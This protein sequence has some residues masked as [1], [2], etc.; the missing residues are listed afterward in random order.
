MSFRQGWK[1]A[2]ERSKQIAEKNLKYQPPLGEGARKQYSKSAVP[3]LA[4]GAYG[5][6]REEGI[7]PFKTP[8][9]FAGNVA[10][11]VA[12]DVGDAATMFEWWSRNHP[13]QLGDSLME[14]QAGSTLNRY[15]PADRSLVTLASVGL[16]VAGTLGVLNLANPAE[17]FRPKGFAQDYSPLGADDRRETEQPFLEGAQ[18]LMGRRGQPLKYA[19]AKQDIPDLTPERYSNYM[20]YLYQDKGPTGLGLIKF[21]GENLEGKP[22]MLLGGFPIGLEAA[23]AIAGGVAAHKLFPGTTRIDTVPKL[24]GRPMGP[25][26]K[27]VINTR[28]TLIVNKKTGEEIPGQQQLRGRSPYK[29]AAVGLAGAVTGILAGKMGNSL[30]AAGARNIGPSTDEYGV[31]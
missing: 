7:T 16:P 6:M 30:V 4:G 2:A 15:M 19:T 21:T 11:M 14:A 5:M 3:F 28:D 12:A 10:R 26:P 20:K 25:A 27:D 13:S 9:R 23:G 18:R 8:K 31:Y 22:E 17:G 24:A 1:E 29:Q